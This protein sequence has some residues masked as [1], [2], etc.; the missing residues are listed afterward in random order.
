MATALQHFALPAT[1]LL[2]LG[3]LTWKTHTRNECWSNK[4]SLWR[5]TASKSPGKFRV[6]GNLGAALAD[7]GKDQEAI[8]HFKK[9]VEIEP[10]FQNGLLN[11]SNSYLRLNQPEASLEV[12]QK[13]VELNGDAPLKAPV[14][15]TI[16]VGLYGVGRFEEARKM[17]NALADAAPNDP[18][19]HR[20]LAHVYVATDQPRPALDHLKTYAKLVPDAADVAPMISELEV[21]LNQ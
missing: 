19:V 18:M 1:A 16:G 4:E 14:A 5:D 15:Y 9:A 21:I 2:I 20:A 12:S 7:A 8:T 11:L 10:R 13:L 3:G 17:L 6:W